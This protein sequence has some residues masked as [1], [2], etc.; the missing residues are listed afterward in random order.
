MYSV[1]LIFKTR[2]FDF[3]KIEIEHL[4]FRILKLFKNVICNYINAIYANSQLWNY[5]KPIDI[6][7]RDYQRVEL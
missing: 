4:K 3:V 2:I 6:M 1:K 5:T 7:P